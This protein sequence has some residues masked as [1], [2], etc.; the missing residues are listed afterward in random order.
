[1]N[2][3]YIYRYVPLNDSNAKG[4]ASFRSDVLLSFVVLN[5]VLCLNE[6]NL[7][8]IIVKFAAQLVPTSTN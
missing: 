6:N 7:L 5:F 4:T 8:K 2:K 3:Y 1:M